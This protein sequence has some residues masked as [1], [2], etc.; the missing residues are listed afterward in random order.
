MRVSVGER[1]CVSPSVT[2]I[3]TEPP[4]LD[5]LLDALVSSVNVK[6]GDS[7]AATVRVCVNRSVSEPL[8][9][10]EKVRGL[11]EIV[12]SSV[13]EAL[14]DSHDKV[15]SSVTEMVVVVL[16]DTMALRVLVEDPPERLIEAVSDRVLAVAV[17]SLE[18]ETVRVAVHKSVNDSE[19]CD[20]DLL[21][22]TDDVA[23]DSDIVCIEVA[24]TE[25]VA[26]LKSVLVSVSVGAVM[27]PVSS[28]VAVAAVGDSESDS[29]ASDT[30]SS[31]VWDCVVDWVTADPEAETVMRSV[32]DTRCTVSVR[33]CVVDHV[34]TVSEPD[35][36]SVIDRVVVSDTLSDADIILVTVSS[37]EPV[38]VGV[39]SESL[40]VP[41]ATEAVSS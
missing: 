40:K 6:D 37:K 38:S 14:R 30:V 26:L 1:D 33:A 16:P 34:G 27:D 8:T 4:L 19:R 5:T 13:V 17:R 15:W 36:S 25:G 28:R 10:A 35:W 3:V 41:V 20:R 29:V 12:V 32:L 23:A 11:A 9:D 24:D 18:S 2:L 31:S 7:V 22:D 39:A 21:G